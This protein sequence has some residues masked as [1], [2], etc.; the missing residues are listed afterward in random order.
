MKRNKANDED[1]EKQDTQPNNSNKRKN[2]AW[3][4]LKQGCH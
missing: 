1:E 4:F 3:L 2:P